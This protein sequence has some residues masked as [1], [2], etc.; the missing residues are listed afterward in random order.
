MEA[1]LPLVSIIVPVREIDWELEDDRFTPTL[2]D[3]VVYTKDETN[4]IVLVPY[5]CTMLRLTV[6]PTGEASKVDETK[7]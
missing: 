2:P 4:S 1:N 5:G 3:S 6:F 7:H